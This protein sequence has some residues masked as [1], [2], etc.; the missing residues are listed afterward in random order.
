MITNSNFI[1][2]P[3]YYNAFLNNKFII[4]EYSYIIYKYICIYK[5]QKNLPI[6]K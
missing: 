3:Y 1:L 2:I 5:F 6:H 4:K